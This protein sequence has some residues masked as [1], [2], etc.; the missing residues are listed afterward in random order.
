MNKLFWLFFGGVFIGSVVGITGANLALYY[1]GKPMTVIEMHIT[2]ALSGI[3][4]LFYMRAC[5]RYWAY[6]ETEDE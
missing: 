2:G 1:T 6:H 4:Y 3:L 5:Y